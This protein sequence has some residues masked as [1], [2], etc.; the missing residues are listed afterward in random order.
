M[1]DYSDLGVGLSLPSLRT[2]SFSIE[3]AKKVQEVRKTGLTFAPEAGTQRLRDVINKGVTEKDIL[4]TVQAAFDAGWQ[5]LKL[6]FMI[7]LPTEAEEDLA[8]IASLS[9]KVVKMA[10]AKV[11][12]SIS[13][14]VPKPHTPFQ[15]VD[16]N[17]LEEIKAKINYL[18]KNVRGKGLSLDWNQPNESLLEAAFARGDR[19]LNKVLKTAWELGCKFDGWSE[20]FDIDLW[21]QAFAEC[22]MNLEEYAY[23]EFNLEGRLPWDHIQVGVNKDYF[24]KEYKQALREKITQ[25]CRAGKCTTCGVLENLEIDACLLGGES[26]S[27]D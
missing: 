8:G 26:N 19:R 4:E 3:L 6:Y 15:W 21:R 10:K 5:K 2:D 17:D 11:K 9:K 25:D 7:G 24:K 14:F 13:T 16:F 22:G 18:Q 1:N 12:V 20:H 23:R 27:E